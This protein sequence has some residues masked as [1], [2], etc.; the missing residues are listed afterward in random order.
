MKKVLLLTSKNTYENVMHSIEQEVSKYEYTCI[1]INEN[2]NV[3]YGYDEIIQVFDMVEIIIADVSDESNDYFIGQASIL[4]KPI[5]FISSSRNNLNIKYSKYLVLIYSEI[6]PIYSFLDQVSQIF[7]MMITNIKNDVNKK[8]VNT[9]TK[10]NQIF[11]SYSHNDLD[12]LQRLMIHLKPLER[13]GSIDVWVDTRIKS[14]E[15]WKVHIQ[16]ALN[17]SGV[18]ILLISADF[19]ASDF[20]INDELPTLLKNAQQNGTRIIP[21][22]VKPCRFTREKTLNIFQSIN[23]P[24]RP[25]NSLSED[26]RELIYD[27]VAQRVEDIISN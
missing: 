13:N 20:I 1:R 14:G 4:K 2:Y 9:R 18:G 8:E 21:I 11:I 7:S 27:S 24:K 26:E 19:I 17:I 10:R 6:E 16:N 15:K 23:D 12:Y 3:Q 22:V 25:L 5:L